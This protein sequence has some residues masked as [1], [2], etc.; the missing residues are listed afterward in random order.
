MRNTIEDVLSGVQLL[1]NGCWELPT[2][3]NSTGYSRVCIGGKRYTGH[4]FLYE[5]LVCQI[6]NG[7]ELDHICR[8][9]GC[10]NPDHL[11]QVTHRENILRSPLMK[12]RSHCLR[13]HELTEENTYVHQKTGHRACRKCKERSR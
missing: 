2:S 6:P 10:V 5:H 3:A 11:E 13:G 7:L 1:E 4:R 9:R 12:K 8:N